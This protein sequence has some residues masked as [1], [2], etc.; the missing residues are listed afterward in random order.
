MRCVIGVTAENVKMGFP[1]F[2][3]RLVLRLSIAYEEKKLYSKSILINMGPESTGN[4]ND[5]KNESK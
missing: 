3:F 1:S 4:W 5:R 2:E